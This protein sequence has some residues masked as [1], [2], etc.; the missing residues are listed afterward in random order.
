ML[1]LTQS[2][3]FTP[4]PYFLIV[5][6]QMILGIAEFALDFLEAE[7]MN[8]HFLVWVQICLAMS[9]EFRWVFEINNR[10]LFFVYKCLILYF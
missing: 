10:K 8:Q 6:S 9:G 3:L 7:L 4:F 1:L 2:I 5:S